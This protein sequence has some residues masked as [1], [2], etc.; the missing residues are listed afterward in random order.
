MNRNWAW[1][2]VVVLLALLAAQTYRLSRCQQDRSDESIRLAE[3]EAKSAGLAAELAKCLK[4]CPQ[5]PDEIPIIIDPAGG[6]NAFNVDGGTAQPTFSGLDLSRLAFGGVK[7]FR[8]TVQ[9]AGGTIVANLKKVTGKFGGKDLEISTTGGA[10]PQF[11]WKLGGTMV[12]HEITSNQDWN[13]TLCQP[14]TGSLAVR[15][16]DPMG[17]QELDGTAV[18]VEIVVLVPGEAQ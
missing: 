8:G 5:P 11:V 10:N 18:R 17:G 14:P 13:A 2:I 16:V 6:G 1:V 15:Y 9:T 4:N 3:A 7:Y 12:S